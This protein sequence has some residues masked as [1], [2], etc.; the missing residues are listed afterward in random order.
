M[1]ELVFIVCSILEGQT[2]RQLQPIPLQPDTHMMACLKA[3]QIEGARWIET[4]PNH[5]IQRSTCQPL[6]RVG[7]A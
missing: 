7:K 5:Y 3:S 6:G 2:C 1:L 4:H